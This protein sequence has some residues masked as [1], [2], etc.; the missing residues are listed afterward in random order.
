MRNQLALA[1]GTRTGAQR[2]QWEGQRGRR[3][4]KSKRKGEGRIIK[5]WVQALANIDI[6]R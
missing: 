1:S 5:S 6:M 4:P 2:K 3:R